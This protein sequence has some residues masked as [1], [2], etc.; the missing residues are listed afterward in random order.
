MNGRRL[1][2]ALGGATFAVL[3]GRALFWQTRRLL[4]V[5]DVHIGK[6]AAFRARGVPV[7]HGTTTGNLER[8]SQ[9]IDATDPTTVVFLG[10]LLHAREALGPNVVAPLADWRARHADVAMVL[11]EGNHDAKAGELPPA[12]NIERIGEPW[13]LEGIAFRHHPVQHDGAVVLAGHMHPVVHLR[14]R[15]DDS[16]R[17]PC[18]W[19]REGVVILPAFGD[20]TGGAPIVREP[21]D[22]VIA[23]A[24]D[25]LFEI[26]AVLAA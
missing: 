22:R 15:A 18:F 7:P 8:L 16:A 21:G 12:L 4:I 23:I 20:F 5:A 10:D 13:L 11:V 6:A 17:L 19:L 26:P 2:V 24:D 25:R 3:P 1:E 14:G 9:L